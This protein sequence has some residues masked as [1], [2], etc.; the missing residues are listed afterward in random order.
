[1]RTELA[2]FLGKTKRWTATVDRI[3]TRRGDTPYPIKTLLL[4]NIHALDESVSIAHVWV[5]APNN[6]MLWPS[7]VVEFSAQVIEY[8]RG[9]HLDRCEEDGIDYGLSMPVRVHVLDESVI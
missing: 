7:D 1:M 2:P 6:P 9:Y 3:S 5:T 8:A 4:R